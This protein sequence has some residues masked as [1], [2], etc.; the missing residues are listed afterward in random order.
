MK[1]LPELKELVLRYKPDIIWSDGDWGKTKDAENVR[2]LIDCL[3][4]NMI[5]APDTYWDATNFL[6][7]LYNESPI[8]DRVVS[9]INDQQCD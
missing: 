6:A 2:R 7:W 3:Y 4:I 8:K 5:E 9:C 1:V